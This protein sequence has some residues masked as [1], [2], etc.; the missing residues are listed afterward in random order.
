MAISII[1]NIDKVTIDRHGLLEDIFKTSV[2]SVEEYDVHFISIK[3]IGEHFLSIPY[4]DVVF[5]VSVDIHDLRDQIFNMF[6]EPSGNFDV[7]LL[8]TEA[9][10]QASN[11]LLN[12]INIWTE[13]TKV[14]LENLSGYVNGNFANTL[15]ILNTQLLPFEINAINGALPNLYYIQKSGYKEGIDNTSYYKLSPLSDFAFPTTD[16]D[17]Y[18]VSEGTDDD[19]LTGEGAKTVEINV[20]TQAGVSSYHTIELSGTTP[21]FIANAYRIISVNV[22]SCGNLYQNQDN[23]KIGYSSFNPPTN[24]AEVDSPMFFIPLETNKEQSALQRIPTGYNA[25]IYKIKAN[26]MGGNLKTGSATIRVMRRHELTKRLDVLGTIPFTGDYTSYFPFSLDK[27]SNA[28]LYIEVKGNHASDLVNV[29][30][31]VDILLLQNV[32]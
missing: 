7:S 3:T 31:T 26:A 12:D 23:I 18:I 11:A 9:T 10:L 17:L 21:V 13:A 14:E 28:D 27:S 16:K 8:A 2:I 32:T 4:K 19:F 5:P 25:H 22:T 1:D 20:E 29:Q 30:C 6:T 24:Y 15:N